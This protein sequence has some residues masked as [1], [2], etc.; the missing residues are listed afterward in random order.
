MQFARSLAAE[1]GAAETT[2]P[3]AALHHHEAVLNSRRFG[4]NLQNVKT[5][6]VQ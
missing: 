4:Y 1:D 3:L 5:I 6:A 2:H